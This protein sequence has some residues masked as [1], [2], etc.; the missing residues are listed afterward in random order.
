[1]SVE[2]MEIAEIDLDWVAPFTN[3]NIW[4]KLVYSA[5]L[6]ASFSYGVILFSGL[7]CFEMNGGDPQKRGLANQLIS[8]AC[9]QGVMFFATSTP[10]VLWKCMIGW[11]YDNVFWIYWS[12]MNSF[13][14]QVIFSLTF[15]IGHRYWTVVVHKRM[16]NVQDNFLA[17]FLGS[18]SLILGS[19]HSLIMCQCNL[20]S[21][22]VHRFRGQYLPGH[23]FSIMKFK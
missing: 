20:S 1:M 7:I 3:W 16:L 21:F 13:A 10:V 17:K 19:W 5:L 6:L 9:L 22:L 14:F 15:I 8:Q 11:N 23:S 4:E 12:I 2:K 18:L